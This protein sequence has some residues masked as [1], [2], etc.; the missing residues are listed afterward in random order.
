MEGKDA[1]ASCKTDVVILFRMFTLLSSE[2][3]VFV[4]SILSP[5]KG[6]PLSLT[7]SKLYVFAAELSTLN[8]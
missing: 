3:I 8:I 2:I 7:H 1:I 6:S 4:I 5:A